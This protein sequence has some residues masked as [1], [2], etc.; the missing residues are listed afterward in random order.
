AVELLAAAFAKSFEH[1]PHAL[2][3][4]ALP[5]RETL[6]HHPPERGVEVAVVQ[7]VVGHL[8]EQRVGVEVEPDLCAVPAGVAEPRGH[9]ATVLGW[10]FR[11]VSGGELPRRPHRRRARRPPPTGTHPSAPGACRRR[12]TATASGLA[13]PKTSPS[14]RSTASPTIDCRS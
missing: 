4:A 3:V 10:C 7:Q 5:V 2:H 8:L 14:T 11:R 6:L 9:V 1:L 13:T 12:A